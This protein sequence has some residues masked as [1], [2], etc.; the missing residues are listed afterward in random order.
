MVAGFT[1]CASDWLDTSPTSSYGSETIF[2]S[3]DNAQAALNGIHKAM[4][5][6]YNSRQNQ[7]GYTGMMQLVDLLGEDLVYPARSNGWWV[8][9]IQWLGHTNQNN[10]PALYPYQFFYMLISNANQILDNI[11]NLNGYDTQRSAIKASALCYR[12]MSYFWLVQLYGTRYDKSGNNSSLACPLIVNTTDVELPLSPVEDVYNQVISDLDEAISL[13]KGITWNPTN[14]ADFTLATAE[15]LRA[16]VAL[17]MQDWSGAETYAKAA[18]SDSKTTLMSQEQWH[19][20]FNDASNPEWMWG[21]EMITDQ[22]LYFYGFMAY[23]SWNFNSSN[24]RGAGKCIFSKLYN[25]ISDTD[26]RKWCWAGATAPDWT[27]PTSSFK[28]FPYMNRKFAVVDYTSSVADAC[29]MRRSELILIAAEAQSHQG[30]DSEAQSTI[31]ELAK[32]RDTEYVKSSKTGADLLEEILIQRRVELWGEGFR[33][34]DLK[35]LNL[36]LDRTGGNHV[37]SVSL[38]M[39]VAAGADEWRFKIPL[40]EIEANQQIPANINEI[41]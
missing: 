15:G 33:F 37:E 24:I 9:E 28:K 11:D 38:Q 36:P 12:G 31:Y 39:Q 22:T 25:E 1:S 2:T 23:M 7:S 8:N 16:R 13:F 29:F 35:R 14:K 18:L 21:F 20:G 3:V 30:K 10:W 4:V 26:C 40:S 27:M 5:A 6:Q 32:A 17:T 41:R 19:E 34:L